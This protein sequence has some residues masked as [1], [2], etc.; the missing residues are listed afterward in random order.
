[1]K[2][3]VERRIGQMQK[4]VGEGPGD[5]KRSVVRIS[6]CGEIYTGPDPSM[7]RYCA[8]GCVS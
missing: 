2:V 8:P 5:R 1:M 7:C 4:L 3:K 6:G